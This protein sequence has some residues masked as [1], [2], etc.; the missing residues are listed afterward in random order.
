MVG[1]DADVRG[2]LLDHLQHGMEHADRSRGGLVLAFVEAPLPV[3]MAEKLVGPV[4]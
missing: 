1:G 3:E 4:D 2:A